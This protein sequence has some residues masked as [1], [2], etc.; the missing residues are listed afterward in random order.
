MTP[1]VRPAVREVHIRSPCAGRESRIDWKPGHRRPV[2]PGAQR[3]PTAGRA[4]A[5]M[6]PMGQSGESVGRQHDKLARRR[7]ARVRVPRQICPAELGGTGACGSDALA[8]RTGRPP[9][10]LSPSAPAPKQRGLSPV[11]GGVPLQSGGRLDP[12]AVRFVVAVPPDRAMLLP[13][14]RVHHRHADSCYRLPECRRGATLERPG[15]PCS[16]G[17]RS[18]GASSSGCWLSRLSRSCCPAPWATSSAAGS[19]KGRHD[20]SWARLPRPRRN[21]SLTRWSAIGSGSRR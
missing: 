3:P 10:P 19:W 16:G 15:G 14:L 17:E 2:W 1:I 11:R 7:Q 5:L 6:A 21:T 18:G 9:S 12:E 20:S 4:G 13:P 8:H